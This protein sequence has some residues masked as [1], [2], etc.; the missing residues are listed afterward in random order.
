[1]TPP[2]DNL[3]ARAGRRKEHE[4]SGERQHGSLERRDGCAHQGLFHPAPAD[5][6]IDGPD[7][8]RAR[9]VPYW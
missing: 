1:M 6:G 4:E 5:A 8:S 3:F 9:R 7:E 2:A